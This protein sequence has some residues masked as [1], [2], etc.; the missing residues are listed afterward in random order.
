MKSKI[1]NESETLI[2]AMR[3]YSYDVEMEFA[4]EK[5]VILK[6]K[7]GKQQ[8]TEGIEQPNQ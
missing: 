2:L 6:G 8:M 1:E 7:S 3:I 4:I 5:C